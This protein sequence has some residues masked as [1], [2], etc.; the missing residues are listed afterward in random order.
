MAAAEQQFAGDEPVREQNPPRPHSWTRILIPSLSDVLL[1]ALIGSLFMVD[2]GWLSL[3]GD[4]DTGW[5]IRTGQ[6]IIS[7]GSVPHTD[8]FSYTKAGQS[9]FA[10]E[11]LSDVLYAGLFAWAGL[12]GIVLFAGLAITGSMVLLLRRMLWDGVNGFVAI[13]LTIMATGAASVHFWARPHVV[14]FAFVGIAMWLLAADRKQK[15]LRVWLLIPLTAVWVNMHGGWA[16]LVATLGVAAVGSA[17]EAWLNSSQDWSMPRRYA[18]LFAGC[19]AASLLNPYGIQLHLHVFEYMRSDWIRSVVHEAQSPQFRSERMLHFELLLIVGV[20]TAGFLIKRRQVVEGLWILLFTHMT[21]ESARHIPLFVITAA[22]YIGAE[23]TAWWRDWVERTSPSSV[24]TILDGIARDL[25]RG[26]ARTSISVLLIPIVLAASEA[27][28][29]KWPRDFPSEV[30]PTDLVTKHAHLLKTS[31]VLTTDQWA[32]YLIYR[33]YP[34]QKVFFDGRSDFYGPEIGNQYLAL[35][36][37]SWNWRNLVERY[38]FQYVLAPVEWPLVS[39]LK[40]AKWAVVDDNGKAILLRR[41]V[42]NATPENAVT[43]LMER[44]LAAEGTG[45]DHHE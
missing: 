13:A 35:K 37:A 6:H 27:P 5:H 29:V 26:A 8:L 10:W 2:K 12:K 34:E 40:S 9:W 24:A 41:P 18:V 15:S 39:V 22:P 16:V 38:R 28:L 30:F 33:F 4:A 17:A 7:S 1:V 45:R 23:V 44:T 19:S 43:A 42:L 21:L 32:D 36:N 3:L 11:W 14:T 20:A 31:K 25:A